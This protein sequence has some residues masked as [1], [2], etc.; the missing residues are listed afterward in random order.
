LV[1][2][3]I[4]KGKQKNI[5][6]GIIDKFSIYFYLVKN[7]E[8]EIEFIVYYYNE[9]IRFKEIK[10]NIIPNGIEVYLNIMDKGHQNNNNNIEPKLLYDLDL[11]N[12]G[13]YIKIK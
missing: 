7:N 12:I 11:N 10:D 2:D 6:V 5:Y 1:Y 4:L 3:D 9:E 8:F 13:F